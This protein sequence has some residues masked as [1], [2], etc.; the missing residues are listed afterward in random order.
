MTINKYIKSIHINHY[1]IHTKIHTPKLTT[2]YLV[3]Q[4]NK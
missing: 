3:L 1:T 4:L 2:I